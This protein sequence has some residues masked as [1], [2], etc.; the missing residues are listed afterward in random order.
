MENR[1]QRSLAGVIGLAVGLQPR[2][3]LA[4]LF[5]HHNTGDSHFESGFITLEGATVVE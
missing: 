5:W 3:N 4:N 2:I 1:P